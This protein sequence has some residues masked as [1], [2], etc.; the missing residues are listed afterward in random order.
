[1][2]MLRKTRVGGH[3]ARLLAG[4]CLAAFVVGCQPIEPDE[5]V[6]PSGMAKNR[7]ARV[8][9]Y[10]LKGVASFPVGIE[11]ETN[12]RNNS[13]TVQNVITADFNSATT[14]GAKMDRS[15]YTRGSFNFSSAESDVQFAIN[16]SQRVH[17]HTLIYYISS[18][19][20]FQN[21]DNRTELEDEAKKHI[22]EF[23]RTYDGRIASVDVANELFNDDGSF[24]NSSNNNVQRWRNLYNNDDEFLQFIGRCFQWARDVDPDGSVK[25]FYNDYGHEY[26]PTK[27]TAIGNFITKLQNWGYPIDGVGLQMHVSINNTYSQI[28]DAIQWAANTGLQV[29]VS[30]LDVSVNPN[31]QSPFTFGDAEKWKQFDG[32]RWVAE[33]Y[34]NFVPAG[35]Q[36]G[37]TVWDVGDADSW[38]PGAFGRVDYATMYDNS[39]TKKLGYYGFLSGLSGS[40]ALPEAFYSIEAV[41]SQKG[42]DIAGVSTTP[43]AYLQQYTYGGGSNQKFKLVYTDG[44]F[45]ITAQ[46]SNLALTVPNQT[47]GVVY[48]EVLNNDWWSQQWQ[49]QS[50]TQGYFAVINRWS[51]LG[52]DVQNSDTNNGAL[53]QQATYTG[54]N[55]QRWYFT[56]R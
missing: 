46:H 7:G 24:Q 30:E 12:V 52:L 33:I 6:R 44:Y 42:L 1:M 9:D 37:I 40:V 39:Y 38:I 26:A 31:Y 21:I 49:L 29:H 10:T 11:S 35:Q 15:Q 3:R 16:N 28:Q 43:G 25:L 20:W 22:Q 51:G 56:L 34:R 19:P 54:A 14:Q 48:Q 4:A 2:L 41:H 47:N 18:P 55:N 36:W 5:T 45:Q 13:S 27:R 32:F 23:M 50:L 53:V 17:A 8:S